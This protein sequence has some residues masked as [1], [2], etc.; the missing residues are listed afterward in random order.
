M[1]E[2]TGTEAFREI[3]NTPDGASRD[4]PVI[5]LTADAVLGA[6]E[7]YLSEGFSDY[8]TKPIDNFALEKMLI[9]HLPKEKVELV[10]EEITD[11]P[12]SEGNEEEYFNTLRS[13]GIEPKSGLKY[14]QDDEVFYRALLAEYAYGELEKAHNIQKSFETENWH[15]YSIYVHALKSSSRMIGASAL[16]MRA[17]KLETAA[18]EED[19]G[20]IQ[21]EHAPMME[22]YE[23]LT[24]VIRS[25]IPKSASDPDNDDIKEYSPAEDIMEFLPGGSDDE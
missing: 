23:V 2:M 8:L 24:A 21:T 16:S 9:K 1:P 15:D 18:N 6:K 12:D 13:V 22:E 4:V 7:R 3:L 11:D 19:T 25:V 17:A 10:K 14:C 20:T 5:C